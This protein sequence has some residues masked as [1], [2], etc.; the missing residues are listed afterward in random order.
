MTV[1]VFRYLVSFNAKMHKLR[2]LWA[3]H[4]EEVWL[5]RR[6]RNINRQCLENIGEIPDL[7]FVERFRLDKISFKKLCRDLRVHSSLRGTKEIPLE[8]KVNK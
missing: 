2:L 5:R 7:L 3:A 1:C 8:I 4:N 6:R